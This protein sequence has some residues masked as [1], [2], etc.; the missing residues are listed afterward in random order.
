MDSPPRAAAREPPG[1]VWRARPSRRTGAA[2]RAIL[3]PL[4]SQVAGSCYAK[5]GPHRRAEGLALSRRVSA[6]S[7]LEG[8]ME[9]GVD[10]ADSRP[11][12][13][14]TRRG[15]LAGSIGLAGALAL[16]GGSPA[17]SVSAA[18]TALP[19]PAQ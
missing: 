6:W 1:R 7:D 8:I 16:G 15:F 5:R 18:T 14:L 2:T 17:T 12:L 9:S 13:D 3:V 4:E 11:W 10:R 19:P